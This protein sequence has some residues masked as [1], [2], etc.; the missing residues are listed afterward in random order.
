MRGTISYL[1]TRS[2]VPESGAL[3]HASECRVVS[4]PNNLV[5]KDTSPSRFAISRIISQV[6]EVTK[7]PSL[8]ED[9]LDIAIAQGDYYSR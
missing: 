2:G 4:Y 6:L 1:S 5:R 7:H 8:T 9:S 3:V